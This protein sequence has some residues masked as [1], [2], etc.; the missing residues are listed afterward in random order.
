MPNMQERTQQTVETP[1]AVNHPPHYGGDNPYEAIKVIEAWGLDFH[2][3]NAVKY[4]ARAGKKTTDPVEDLRKAVWYIERKIHT[5]KCC[6]F[7]DPESAAGTS[8][9]SATGGKL[10]GMVIFDASQKWLYVIDN[11]KCRG[12]AI[13]KKTP[14]PTGARRGYRRSRRYRW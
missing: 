12:P 11:G 3:G 7:A 1:E 5:L 8:R 2:L 14:V 4:I 13:V 6:G 10:K 9:M